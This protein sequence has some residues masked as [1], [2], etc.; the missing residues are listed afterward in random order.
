MNQREKPNDPGSKTYTVNFNESKLKQRGG[1]DVETYIQTSE[2]SLDDKG[3]LNESRLHQSSPYRQ[4][5]EDVVHDGL[6]IESPQKTQTQS[7][8]HAPTS[9][10]R[11]QTKNRKVVN[12]NL[13]RLLEGVH[14]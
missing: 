9:K 14:N 8:L 2:H 1:D 7:F 4:S 5:I 10:K 13:H 3:V 11:A 6:D 12:D